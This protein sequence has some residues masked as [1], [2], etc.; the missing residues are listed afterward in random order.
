MDGQVTKP[1]QTIIPFADGEMALRCW[2]NPGKPLLLFA[3][4]N[5]FCGSA[6]VPLLA[7]LGAEY[8]IWV[9][10]LRGHGQ[11]RLPADPST[12]RSWDIYA[13]DLLQLIDRIGRQPDVMA[14][15]SMGAVSSLLTAS[16]L[17]HVPALRLIEPV[18]LPVS[19]YLMAS[20]PLGSLMKGRLPIARQA[21]RR[22]N[23]WPDRS[24]A[25]ARYTNHP[26]FKRWA[27]GLLEAYLEGGLTDADDGRVVLACDPE[28][29][30]VNYEAQ[31]HDIGRAARR[32]AP[33]ARVLKAEFGST[34]VRPGALTKRGAELTFMDGVGH[35]APM[36]APDRVRDWLKAG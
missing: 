31:G 5:G 14:G 20:G 13:D 17:E 19:V 7:P 12:H 11:T 28:W 23:G 21:R 4:A 2:R 1:E 36:E 27:P 32:A 15:H 16:R 9:P 18:V 10:D 29:E 3:H 35:L 25:L 33:R 22:R 26:T 30:A 24:A 6:Y 34:V 8:E